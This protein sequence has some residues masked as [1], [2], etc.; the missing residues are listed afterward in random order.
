MADKQVAKPQQAA[1]EENKEVAKIG[2]V[3]RAAILL[4][5]L[6]EK[7]AAELLRHMGP[8][9]VQDVGLAMATLTDVTT[10][11]MEAVMRHF[12]S[13]L[14]KQ[15]ALGLGSDEYIRNMLTN[16]LGED[17]AGGVIDRI[18]LG[19]NSKGLEQLKWMDPRAIAELIRLEHPQIIAIVLSF[20]EADQ[21][22]Q[23]VSQFPERVRTD[24]VMRIATLDGIQPAALQELDE[25]LEKQFSGATN[26]KSSSLG[27]IKTAAEI[28]NMLDGAVESKLMEEIIEIDNDLGQELQDNM[29]VFENL[30]DVDD[31]GIQ[32]LLREVSTEQLLLAMRGA[33]EVLKEKIFKNMSKRAAEMLKDDLEAA[34][35]AKLSDVEAAQKEILV[36]ARRLADAGEIMLGGGGEE[37]V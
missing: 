27:G 9:E 12:V 32:S 13:T 25:I 36:V 10:D 15:T 7:D 1:P 16:A 23:V 6:G 31:R 33:D 26:V 2:G 21:A 22:A 20:L 3:S 29:F 19:R 5:A 30:I 11:Q 37:F 28:L 18:L 35:P 17:K 24:V 14:E 8:K 4:L 34:P